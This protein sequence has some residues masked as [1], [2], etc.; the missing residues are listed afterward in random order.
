MLD[1]IKYLITNID[2]LAAAITTLAGVMATAIFKIKD[3]IGTNT[4]VFG[5]LQNILDNHATQLAGLTIAQAELRKQLAVVETRGRYA[6]EY[7]KQHSYVRDLRTAI[8]YAVNA[9]VTN[10]TR[11]MCERDKSNFTSL[12]I[13][14]GRRVGELFADVYYQ[15]CSGAAH[16]DA[17]YIHNAAIAHLRGVRTGDGARGLG[18]AA[19][20]AI[21]KE[22]AHQLVNRAVTQIAALAR[23]VKGVPSTAPELNIDVQLQR[24]ATDFA[25]DFVFQSGGVIM[26]LGR[27][28]EHP[29]SRTQ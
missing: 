14:A 24:I 8:N 27:P 13:E 29:A 23:D 1:L 6:D 22:V 28:S 7:A 11:Q 15:L 18:E 26:R 19:T 4:K 12:S 25:S 5:S 2:I 17:E 9:A 3:A 10:S 16:I 20:D 21:R